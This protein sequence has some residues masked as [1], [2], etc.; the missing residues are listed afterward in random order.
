VNN[1]HRDRRSA[2]K[3]DFRTMFKLTK[4]GVEKTLYTFAQ[5]ENPNGI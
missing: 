4:K 5:C 2:A 3:S 1:R